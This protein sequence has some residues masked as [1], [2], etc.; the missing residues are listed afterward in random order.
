VERVDGGLDK[1]PDNDAAKDLGNDFG[2]PPGNGEHKA[3]A[4]PAQA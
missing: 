4:R 2:N 1:H 3:G